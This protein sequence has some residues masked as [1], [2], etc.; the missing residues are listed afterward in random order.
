MAHLPSLESNRLRFS[1]VASYR[2]Q[3]RDDDGFKKHNPSIREVLPKI[4]FIDSL[5]HLSSIEDDI[6]MFQDDEMLQRLKDHQR[7]FDSRH[8]CRRCFSVLG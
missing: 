7:M 6:L 2:G 4:Y 8:E 5:R 1:L 3:L